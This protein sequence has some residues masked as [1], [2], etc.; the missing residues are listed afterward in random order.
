MLDSSSRRN[1]RRM[2]QTS[3]QMVVNVTVDGVPVGE[4]RICVAHDGRAVLLQR[5][6]EGIVA[7]HALTGVA[8]T[9][10]GEAVSVEADGHVW[11][12]QKDQRC[13]SCGG[14]YEI[15]AADARQF[16]PAV[17]AVDG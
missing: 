11:T 13:P 8:Y 2:M 1:V 4:G 17:E 16:L 7:T 14:R 5:T 6:A 15:A 12:A 3:S 9:V 10:A